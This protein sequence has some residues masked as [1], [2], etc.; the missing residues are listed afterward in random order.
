MIIVKDKAHHMVFQLIEVLVKISFCCVLLQDPIRHFNLAIC[1]RVLE[2]RKSMFNMM[3]L[4]NSIKRVNFVFRFQVLR[5]RFI[6]KLSPII[7]EDLCDFKWAMGDEILEKRCR[8]R[9]C[10]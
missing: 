8:N 9:H 6:G 7:C 2:F 1:P 10:H 3:F 4:A 5:Q